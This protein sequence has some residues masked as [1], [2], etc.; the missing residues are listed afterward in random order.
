MRFSIDTNVLVY[1]FAATEP[2]KALRARELLRASLLADCVLTLQCLGE[3]LH[4]VTRKGLI[5][6]SVATGHIERWLTAFPAVAADVGCVRA[7][8]RI[9]ASHHLSYWDA[10]LLATLREARCSVLLS[11]DMQHG[12]DYDGVRV[13][14]PFLGDR[15]SDEIE[16]LL[17]V[18]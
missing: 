9:L 7:A 10:L 5:P 11:E 6:P 18:D 13:L 15:L 2:D 4:A 14:N 8:L 16:A 17:A 12:G 1:L 3:F